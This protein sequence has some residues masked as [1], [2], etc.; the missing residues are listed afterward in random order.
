MQDVTIT[1]VDG[2]MRGR[3]FEFEL[4]RVQI[5]RLPEE[6]GLELKG[7]DTSVSRLHAELAERD[8]DV[9]L[10]NLSPAG[11]RV[12]GQLII[13]SL[14]L[15]P[16][17]RI[18]IG[19]RHPFDVD[20]VSIQQ[21]ISPDS[22]RTQASRAPSKPG[23]LSS[24]VVRAV[25]GVYL[26]GMVAVVVWLG[27]GSGGPI[28]ADDWPELKAAYESYTAD[29]MTGAERDS[30]L[31][32]AEILLRELRANRTQGNGQQIER[33]CREIMRIDRRTDSPLFRYGAGCLASL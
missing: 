7:S 21:R 8:G 20:W 19:P 25:L 18:E 17:A 5:G 26:A 1:F 15:R 13:D 27:L 12:D 24:P 9:E 11:T 30:N 4:G 3:T 31:A 10:R 29:S 14:V 16:G 33:L 22:Q 6:G 2:P 32:R 23:P 28:A